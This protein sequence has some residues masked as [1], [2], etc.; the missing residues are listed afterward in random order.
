MT[1]PW[2]LVT[3]FAPSPTG[4]LHLGHAHSALAGWRAARQA[5]GRFLLRIEDI[6]ATRCQPTFAAAIMEDLAWLGLDWD[7][8]VRVQSRHM[9]DYGR[10]LDALKARGLLFPCFCTRSDIAREIAGS[11]AAPHGPDGPLYPGTCRRLPVAE[12][13]DRMAQAVPHAWRLDMPRALADLPAPL[14]FEEAGRGRIACDPARFGDV[15][16]A[17]KEV[18]ASYHLCVTHDDARDGVTLVTR[19][20]DLL[21]A[22][23]LHRLLQHLMGW[24]EPAYAHHQLL[25]GR[26]GRRLSKRDGAVPLRDLRAR[27][28]P[29]GEA[30][31]MAGFP[32]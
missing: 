23:D 14:S 1:A 15:V 10:T 22:T 12:R 4:F 13:Q 30:R 2:P 25:T 20:E 6:D 26:D 24:P 9:N 18:P 11:A 19:G 21:P 8:P 29:P 17:R 31:A 5:G 3:R 27:G 7:G 16:L 32:G 28:V